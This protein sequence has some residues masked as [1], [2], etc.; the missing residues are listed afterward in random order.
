M[1]TEH[2]AIII[3]K[4]LRHMNDIGFTQFRKGGRDYSVR[5]LACDL[6]VGEVCSLQLV[7]DAMSKG[8]KQ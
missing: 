1:E 3:A 2:A 4:F 6:E 8:I 5:D 7:E